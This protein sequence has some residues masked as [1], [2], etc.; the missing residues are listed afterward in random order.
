MNAAYP[1]Y[2]LK[3]KADRPNQSQTGAEAK[4]GAAQTIVA[5]AAAHPAELL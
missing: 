1:F 3:G 4:D 5:P 2:W